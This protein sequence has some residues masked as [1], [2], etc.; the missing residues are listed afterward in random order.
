MIGGE[1]GVVRFPGQRAF[2]PAR[3]PHCGLSMVV[4]VPDTR[5]EPLY[6]G[7]GSA[8]SHGKKPRFFLVAG[9]G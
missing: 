6:G 5:L 4:K 8:F 9:G 7:T 3:T 1:A 2:Q